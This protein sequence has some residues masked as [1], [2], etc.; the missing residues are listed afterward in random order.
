M[1]VLLG[2]LLTLLAQPL[3]GAS[4]SI[5]DRVTVKA[6][7]PMGVPV[8]LESRSSLFARAPDGSSG[9]VVAV[10]HGG[11]WLRIR[12]DFGLKGWIVAKYVDRITGHQDI[13]SPPDTSEAPSVWAGP[14]ACLTAIDGDGRLQKADSALRVA[15]WNIRWF[16]FGDKA[17]DI[18]GK[19]TDLHW[20]ACA[21][22]WLD[23]EI[24]AV[25]EILTT[26]AAANAMDSV[27][28]QLS[29]NTGGEWRMALSECGSGKK[30]HVGFIWDASRVTLSD[31]RDVWQFNGAAT[32]ETNPCQ[33]SLRPGFYAYVERKGGGADFHLFA[34]HADSGVSSRDLDNRE[35][36]LARMGSV[37]AP[38]LDRDTDIIIAGD[39]N[40]MGAGDISA[41][42][43]IKALAST[44]A[45]ETPGFDHRVPYPGCSH[46]YSSKAGMLDHILV[47]TGMAE[48]ATSQP[49][50]TGYCAELVCGRPGSG[51]F[52]DM[53]L[54]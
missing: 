37:M 34:V 48:A 14:D 19:Y 27:L 21:L 17:T 13:A 32:G 45:S 16:P 36:A 4:A 24:I 9:L 10:D 23:A 38:L 47:A 3:W 12:F 1:R 41:D 46:Y 26:P 5:G 15:T 25:Q 49:V 29:A 50:T 31:Q 39:F 18:P 33:N 53:P 42:T 11:R 51:R 44:V 30:Q 7:N 8:H 54:A 6:T 52:D 35:R 40:T 43:E 28:A 20:L 2:L 22:T